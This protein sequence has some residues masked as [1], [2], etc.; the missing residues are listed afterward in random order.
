ML[1][2]ELLK[3]NCL[4]FDILRSCVSWRSHEVGQNFASKLDSQFSTNREEKHA[5]KQ[6]LNI[7][8]ANFK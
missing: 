8:M 3:I 2:Q 5:M 4:T 7:L 6:T 1:V